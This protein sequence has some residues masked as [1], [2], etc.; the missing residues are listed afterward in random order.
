MKT[1]TQ[2]VV[3]PSFKPFGKP[4]PLAPETV[5]ALP[6]EQRERALYQ[7]W[8]EDSAPAPS[9]PTPEPLPV[10][11]AEEVPVAPPP[12]LDL[13]SHYSERLCKRLVFLYTRLWYLSTLP[14]N[15]KGGA[16]AGND[17][18]A[19]K[20]RMPDGDR[21]NTDTVRKWIVIL[22][23]HGWVRRVKKAKD[24][25][26]ECLVTPAEVLPFFRRFSGYFRGVF[27][28]KV[29][30]PH[31]YS[32]RGLEKNI[33]QGRPERVK[34]EPLTAEQERV[35]VQAANAGMSRKDA[36]AAVRKAGVEAVNDALTVLQ[37]QAGK[38]RGEGIE[39][40]GA[41]LAGLVKRAVEGVLRLPRAIAEARAI[42]E[43]KAEREKARAARI[44]QVER[45]DESQS[46]AETVPA[47]APGLNDTA[48]LEALPAE[49]IGLLEA[50]AWQALD[51]L[52]GAEAMMAQKLKKAK[53]HWSESPARLLRTAMV[54]LLDSGFGETMA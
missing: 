32:E 54:R 43:R 8:E 36:E 2:P 16:Y 34:K 18:Y 52:T 23:K 53:R 33:S 41:Y 42:A 3:K 11:E 31:I 40:T 9:A 17:W 29:P 6:P 26:I 12:T 28:G 19:D 7:A 45:P 44:V 15:Q 14:Q 27:R 5:A 10:A 24:R 51:K 35:V 49:Q 22:E 50:A 30:S 46:V 21:P 20:I 38:K 37:Y 39:D 13:D 4:A 25:V 1:R 48:R 47:T